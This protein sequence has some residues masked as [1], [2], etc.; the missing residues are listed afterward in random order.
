MLLR[1][2][3]TT[4]NA[5]RRGLDTGDKGRI[6]MCTFCNA[7]R[8]MGIRG[9]IRSLWYCL[10]SQ[11][12]GY[13]SLYDIDRE[14]A[15][16]LD[17]FRFLCTS[18]F[19]SMQQAWST[20]LTQ[21]VEFRVSGSQFISALD[22][23]GYQ[24]CESGQLFDYLLKPGVTD[25]MAFRPDV[26]FLQT[27]EDEKQKIK[28]KQQGRLIWQNRDPHRHVDK[29][30]RPYALRLA[31]DGECRWQKFKDFLLA[32]FQTLAAAFYSMD[33]NGTGLLTLADFQK[34]VCGTFEYCRV[35]E[36]RR[37]FLQGLGGS[38]RPMTWRDFGVEPEEWVRFL[39]EIRWQ[40][41]LTRNFE[42]SMLTSKASENPRAQEA[43]N[44]HF[45]RLKLEV[46]KPPIA[47]GATQTRPFS[48]KLPSPRPGT[49]MT[50]TPRSGV[51]RFPF[52]RPTRPLVATAWIEGAGTH[53]SMK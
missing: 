35:S 30:A 2:Y 28:E 52:P 8:K 18:K 53:S 48:A 17:K 38:L 24:P 20:L 19:G 36:A 34:V 7:T 31:S 46:E 23:L 4:V 50:A 9:Q 49:S 6:D 43:V 37:I 10:D 22:K 27:W 21:D 25:A 29:A 32:R 12:I 42:A 26:E 51:G 15:E 13:L 14:A 11:D 44:D 41:Q 39:T 1:L 47:F 40:A 5:W 45:R 33:A 3:G 16:A